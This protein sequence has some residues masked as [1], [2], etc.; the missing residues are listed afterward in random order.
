MFIHIIYDRATNEEGVPVFDGLAGR[1]MVMGDVG[2]WTRTREVGL[3]GLPEGLMGVYDGIAAGLVGIGGDWVAQQV[4]GCLVPGD[5]GG[6]VM[7]LRVEAVRDGDGAVRMFSSE[8][9]DGLRI[10]DEGAVSAVKAG[11][12]GLLADNQGD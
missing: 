4:W 8:D 10:D 3:D 9:L 6:E 7:E 2:G 1:M 12:E 11:V 5:D